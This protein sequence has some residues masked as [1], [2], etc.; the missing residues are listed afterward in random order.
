MGIRVEKLKKKVEKM[1]LSRKIALAMFLTPLLSSLIIFV[2]Y[3]GYMKDFYREKVEIFQE[4][5]RETMCSNVKA[6]LRQVDYVS[7]Q[8]LGLAVLSDDFSGYSQKNSYERMLLNKEINSLLINIS[9]SNEMIDN[10]YL[11]D[12]DGNTFTSN[13]DWD[14]Q[15]YLKEMDIS[16]SREQEGRREIVP[17]H[18]VLY[19]HISGTSSAPYMI[20]VMIYL[21]RYTESESI[22]L[23]QIDIAYEKMREAMEYVEMTEEDFAFVVDAEGNLIYAPEKEDA[24]RQASEASYGGYQLGELYREAFEKDR[25]SFLQVKSLGKA[26]WKL[27]QVNGDSMLHEELARIQKT[28]ILIFVVCL[29]CAACFSLSLSHSITKPVVTLIK[30]MGEI[31]RGNF[32]IQVEQPE[33]P[34]LA[35]LVS[36]FNSMI[37]E[38]DTLMKENIQKEHDKTRMEMMALNAKINSHFLYNTLNTIKWQAIA[39]KQMGI[40]E[41]IVALT[42]ILEYSFR[43]TLDMVS[44]QDELKFIEDYIYIQRIRYACSVEMQYNMEDTCQ[45]CLVPKM[46]LQPIVENALLHAFDKAAKDNRIVVSCVSE[47]PIMRI[48]V[49]DNGKGFDYQ[50]FDRLT[51]I[52]LTN[53]MDRLLLNFGERGRLE[54]ESEVGQGT[55]VI[56]EMP[57]MEAE[58]DV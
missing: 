36:S 6:L 2:L 8:V 17:P 31:S 11:V 51:G 38:V 37:Q 5:N 44:L 16:L 10:I 29:L 20:S 52:G 12:F 50:G 55:T 35:E 34:E 47:A 25:P 26:G 32:N 22:G 24:G 49:Y 9:I 14:R 58:R 15:Q 48:T 4:N 43:N 56:M 42:K 46:I 21:N 39:E 23:V 33:Q 27:I 3:Y 40:A 57:L 53:V 19:R 7:S 13:S 1:S 41:S 30:S 45:N 28:W 54:I 18:Q